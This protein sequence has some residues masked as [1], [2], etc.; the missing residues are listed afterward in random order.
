[1]KTGVYYLSETEIMKELICSIGIPLLKGCRM[2][3]GSPQR[4]EDYK[5][6]AGTK[7]E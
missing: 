4:S 6:T 7:A 2:A 3:A 5:R 1:M